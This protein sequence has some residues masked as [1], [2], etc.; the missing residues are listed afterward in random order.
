MRLG[1][2]LPEGARIHL[3]F[4]LHGAARLHAF[5]LVHPHQPA[6]PAG[7]PAPPA[8]PPPPS[9]APASS[10]PSPPFTSTHA[11]PPAQQS[12]RSQ[13][14]P[15]LSRQHRPRTPL[16]LPPPHAP[17]T[18]QS[19]VAT[20][21]LEAHTAVVAASGLATPWM[22]S[23]ETYLSSGVFAVG[24]ASLLAAIWVVRRPGRRWCGSGGHAPC[25]W[26]LSFSS[27]RQALLS[28]VGATGGEHTR[29]SPTASS[30]ST[31]STST[32]STATGSGAA[33][34]AL[35]RAGAAGA[36]VDVELTAEKQM[37]KHAQRF[38]KLDEHEDVE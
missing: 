12:P 14:P 26:C 19:P 4:Y 1:E 33:G 28:R 9:P 24:L 20:A 17:P 22:P 11:Q 27:I 13:P 23:T 16:P 8:M 18:P 36:A 30:A 3:R 25:A 10:T 29:T 2:V 21:V 35:T 34:A 6:V 15:S 37:A 5:Q 7:S 38:R 32:S 31:S